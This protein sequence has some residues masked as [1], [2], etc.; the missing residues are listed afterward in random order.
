MGLRRALG[1]VLLAAAIGAAVF[2]VPTVWGKPFRIE[3]YYARI[4]IEFALEHPMLLSYA[5]ILEPYGLDFHSDEL[6]DLSDENLLRMSDQV[7]GFLEGLDAYDRASQTPGQLLST[8]I[9]RWFLQNQVDRK[10]F[11]MHSLPVQQLDGWQS[12]LPDFLVNI[13]QVHSERDAEN[14]LARLRALGP[15][16][17]QVMDA[18]RSRQ[19][20]SIL[21][22]RFVIERVRAAL[23][24]FMAPAAADH[25][26]V[27]SF[28]AKLDGAGVDASSRERSPRDGRPRSSM[29]W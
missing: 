23:E 19:Q 5:R 13:H 28:A 8:D 4:L 16:L 18:M 14:Y 6:E 22:P 20:L 24:D 1:L 25:V 2:T 11:L 17:E 27:T 7:A 3:H 29:P 21:P 9:L 12:T 26:L 15:A 10:P